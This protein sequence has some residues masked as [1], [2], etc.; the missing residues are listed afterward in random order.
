MR[1]LDR[2]HSACVHPRRV[3]VLSSLLA[4]LL[5]HGCTVLDVG[6]GD[7]RLACLLSERRPDL[8]V[9]GVDISAREDA[10]IP[11]RVF[12]GKNL[13]FDRGSVDTVLLVDVLHHAEDPERLL[14]EAVRVAGGSVLV[15]D[16]VRRGVLAQRR[17][18]CMD[19]VGNAQHGVPLPYR[20]WSLQEWQDVFRRLDVSIDVWQDVPGLYWRPVEWLFGGRLHFLARLRGREDA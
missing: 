10:R 3:S 13:P 1:A 18:R 15:K 8:H 11:V 4:E 2:I 14:A 7:G 20:Y 5:P 6:C 9:S 17:L 19:W 12:D 16:H